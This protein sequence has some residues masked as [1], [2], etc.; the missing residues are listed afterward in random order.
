MSPGSDVAAAAGESAG[1]NTDAI[2]SGAPV[3]LIALVNV[4]I[5]SCSPV[6]SWPE[7]NTTRAG[8][9]SSDGNFVDFRAKAVTDSAFGGRNSLCSPLV[10]SERAG[11]TE[12]APVITRSQSKIPREAPLIPDEL[13]KKNLVRI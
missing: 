2:L 5:A 3:V 6:A 11:A 7:L 13:N 9:P 4:E 1:E 12:K 8:T 10:T